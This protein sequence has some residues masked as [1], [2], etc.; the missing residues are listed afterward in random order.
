MG[1]TIQ[2]CTSGQIIDHIDDLAVGHWQETESGFS[3][4]KPEPSRELYDMLEQSGALIAF[5]AYDGDRMVGYVSA[6]LYRHPHYPMTVAQHDTL[7]LLPEYRQGSAAL[8]M[9]R[10]VEVSAAERGAER[11]MW[12]AKLDSQFSHILMAKGYHTEE[13]I[14]SKELTPCQQQPSL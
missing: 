5:G 13:T 11:M 12:H 7:Y 6:M 2:P 3:D 14:F 9:M 8:R 1:I 10:A 4:R